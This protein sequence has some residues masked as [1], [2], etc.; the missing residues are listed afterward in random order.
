MTLMG[1]IKKMNLRLTKNTSIHIK[2]W[3]LLVWYSYQNTPNIIRNRDIMVK[4]H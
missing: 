2:S 1:F 3:L 4:I